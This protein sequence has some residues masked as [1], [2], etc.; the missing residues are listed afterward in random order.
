MRKQYLYSY[1]YRVTNKKNGK[2]YI[3]LRS[4]NC[5]PYLDDYMGSGILICKS[6]QKHGIEYFE[7]EILKIFNNRPEAA[8]FEAVMVDEYVLL[9]PLCLNLKAGGEIETWYSYETCKKISNS[10]KEAYRNDPTYSLRVSANVKKAYCEISGY[11][12]AISKMRK[13]VLADPVHREKALKA[14]RLSF[15]T[16]DRAIN[17]KAGLNDPKVKLKRSRIAKS[18]CATEKGKANL[19]KATK[20]TIYMNKDGETCRIDKNR[21][22][23]FLLLGWKIGSAL[24]VTL[25]TRAKLSEVVSGRIWMYN[26]ELQKNIRAKP[27]QINDLL[28]FG[29]LKGHRRWKPEIKNS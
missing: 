25:D 12:E 8:L 10:I 19:S 1:V 18:Y 7:K 16:T 5:D 17:S 21:T 9:D 23:E 3:G 11:R 29:W 13:R 4:C 20:N 22:D 26:T 15:A 24:I 27:D 6:I 14:V 28:I 2:Y